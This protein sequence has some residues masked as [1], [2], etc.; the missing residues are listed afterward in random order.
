MIKGFGRDVD[1]VAHNIVV[2]RVWVRPII[3]ATAVNDRLS[4]LVDTTQHPF[5]T[6]IENAIAIVATD[7]IQKVRDA[8][9]VAIEGGGD[10]L[11]SELKVRQ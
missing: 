8:I 6:N 5:F 11:V 1:C 9:A 10:K 7:N 3:G 2:E 4:N